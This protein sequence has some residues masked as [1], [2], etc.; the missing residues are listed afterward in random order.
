MPEFLDSIIYKPVRIFSQEKKYIEDT[1]LGTYFPWFYI[2]NQTFDNNSDLIP[3]SVR[4]FVNYTNSPYLSHTLLARSN[5]ENI[6][7]KDRPSTDFSRYYE[8][9]I[10]IFHRFM[11]DNNQKYSKIY[12]ANLNLSWFNGI[13]HTEPHFD[14]HWPHKNFIMYLNDCSHGQTIIWPSD[15]LTSYTI[16]CKKYYAVAFDS[17]LHGHRFPAPKERRVVFV[18]T[19]I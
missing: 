10:E 4:S 19:F 16:P 9:F 17:Q 11:S 6:S 1:V 3:E 5:F 18:V 14:H 13:N 15:F 2:E 12:R 7:N 8:F